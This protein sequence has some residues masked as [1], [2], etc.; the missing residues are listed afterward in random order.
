MR[1]LVE[2]LMEPIYKVRMDAR[3]RDVYGKDSISAESNSS[4]E[5]CLIV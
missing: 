1:R 3:C 5:E 2:E 4:E